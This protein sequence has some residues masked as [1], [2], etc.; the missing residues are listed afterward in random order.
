MEEDHT[1]EDNLHHEFYEELMGLVMS[2]KYLQAC[3]HCLML[4][5]ARVAGQV[6]HAGGVDVGS[7]SIEG[8][9][10]MLI[11]WKENAA[12]ADQSVKH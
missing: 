12:L 9:A 11:G 5:L 10:A 1:T 2:E 6:A 8:P 7:A 4:E 3:P